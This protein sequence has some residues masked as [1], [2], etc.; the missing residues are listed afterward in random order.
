MN[1]GWL[2]QPGTP[3]SALQSFVG[4]DGRTA[5]IWFPTNNELPSRVHVNDEIT[6]KSMLYGALG[7]AV[8]DIR[9]YF[10]D[11]FDFAAAANLSQGSR[12]SGGSQNSTL[13][14]Q[15]TEEVRAAVD[16][17]RHQV[18][19]A[20]NAP[21]L[22]VCKTEADRHP[23]GDRDW[24]SSSSDGSA[25]S[26]RRR[27]RSLGNGPG[28]MDRND[29]VGSHQTVPTQQRVELRTSPFRQSSKESRYFTVNKWRTGLN[30]E[31]RCSPTPV[32][33]NRQLIHNTDVSMESVVAV[34]PP[35]LRP[36]AL[37]PPPTIRS[38]PRQDPGQCSD[39]IAA[40]LSTQRGMDTL[41]RAVQD[42]LRSEG[43]PTP[44]PSHNDYS[45]PFQ[46]HS[47]V[48][49]HNPFSP[50]THRPDSNIRQ[51]NRPDYQHQ[52]ADY[53]QPSVSSSTAR[54]DRGRPASGGHLN[55]YSATE[56]D[57]V[58]KNHSMRNFRRGPGGSGGSFSGTTDREIERGRR[59]DRNLQ[60]NREPS[61]GPSDSDDSS[62]DEGRRE[63]R[64]PRRGPVS[65]THL[66]LP[67]ILRV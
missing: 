51:H 65:Y 11:D 20:A 64:P 50:V 59:S 32:P 49:A 22:A 62:D 66:T 18:K 42:G 53:V 60:G 5:T 33:L 63:H 19:P 15:N 54:S 3:Q 17:A 24:S 14:L 9:G 67:T 4:G 48:G 43:I 47:P 6:I 34:Q 35:G 38:E 21:L 12:S 26:I 29:C 2:P 56:R 31:P 28:Q 45:V 16:R 10:G 8:D 30:S 27:S 13:P 37:S 39:Q 61:P 57:Q 52:T 58:T 41:V 7:R 25:A 23:L 40:F 46:V 55:Y 44:P 36:T 1:C